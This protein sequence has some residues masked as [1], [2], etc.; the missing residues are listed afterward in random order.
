MSKLRSEAVLACPMCMPPTPRCHRKKRF[1]RA[2]DVNPPV[3]VRPRAAIVATGTHRD[4]TG[5]LTSTAHLA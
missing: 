1:R 3:T 2:G 5:R 4:V